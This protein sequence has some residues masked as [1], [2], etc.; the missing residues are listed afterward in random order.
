MSSR[1]RRRLLLSQ[2]ANRVYYYRGGKSTEEER[3]CTDT[4]GGWKAGNATMLTE[5]NRIGAMMPRSQFGQT[6]H[7]RTVNKV[8][9]TDI[10]ALCFEVEKKSTNSF[11]SLIRAGIIASTSA[12]NA[13]TFN[14]SYVALVAQEDP[15]D[16][17]ILLTVDTTKLT[18]T[19]Y[20]GLAATIAA[21]TGGGSNQYA[22]A[23]AYNIYGLRA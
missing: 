4:T 6:R 13:S 16:K 5:D 9:L 21:A 12:T 19:Y 22:Y 17:K 3:Q 20:L 14:S 23:Y 10:N 2:A 1:L 11:P 8:N 15:Y 18:G 7:I